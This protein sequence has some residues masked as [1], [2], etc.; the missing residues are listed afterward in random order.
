MKTYRTYFRRKS[1]I[2]G[3]ESPASDTSTKKIV[4]QTRLR[5]T[6]AVCRESFSSEGLLLSHLAAHSQP[7]VPVTGPTASASRQA[8]LK[9]Q[10]PCDFCPNSFSTFTRLK[11]HSISVHG[12]TKPLKCLT[13][14]TRF[15]D[16]IVLRVHEEAKHSNKRQPCDICGKSFSAERQDSYRFLLFFY[17]GQSPGS[18]RFFPTSYP[19]NDGAR[20]LSMS[21]KLRWI[22]IYVRYRVPSCDSIVLH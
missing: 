7:E 22:Y 12:E 17:Y 11:E 13:C 15:R 20:Y 18:G 14:G 5:H 3:I 21:V 9:Q 4:D 8:A 10:H 6:C 19:D 16:R 1:E 2:L